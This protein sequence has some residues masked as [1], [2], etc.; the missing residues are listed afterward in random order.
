M[1]Q[2]IRR[3]IG[4]TRTALASR[5][6]AEDAD[7]VSQI[8]DVSAAT[9]QFKLVDCGGV[10][11]V[12][13]NSAS[14]VTDGTDGKVKYDFQTSDY[15]SLGPGKYYGYFIVTQASETDH[16]PVDPTFQILFY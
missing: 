2:V 6:V 9:L 10:V 8:V 1:A 3:K 4:D 11:V 16:F 13:P 12:G 5:L 15:A 14:F 7:G